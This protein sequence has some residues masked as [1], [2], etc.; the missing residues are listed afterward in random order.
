MS[1]GLSRCL[2]VCRVTHMG[3]SSRHNTSRQSGTARSGHGGWPVAQLQFYQQAQQS[4]CTMKSMQQG[5]GLMCCPRVERRAWC[6][7]VFAGI[8]RFCGDVPSG[9]LPS[10]AVAVETA[11][12]LLHQVRHNEDRFC[13]TGL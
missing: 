1:A 2:Q 12:K 7:C 4:R 3:S 10:Q 9:E 8:L 5:N 6:P 11:Q 13:L